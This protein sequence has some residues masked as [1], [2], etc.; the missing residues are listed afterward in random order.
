MA[1]VDELTPE[2]KTPSTGFVREKDFRW[3]LIGKS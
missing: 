2:F 1:I 3:D